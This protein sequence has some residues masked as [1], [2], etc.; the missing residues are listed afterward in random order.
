MKTSILALSLML[1]GA[2]L[3]DVESSNVF[4]L[5]PVTSTQKETLLAVPFVAYSAD[6]TSSI[7]VKDLVKTANLTTGDRLL[8][9]NGSTYYSWTLKNSAWTPDNTAY[10]TAAGGKVISTTA[11]TQDQTISRGDAIWLVRTDTSKT[12]Y[13]MGQVGAVASLS[14]TGSD[15]GT[16]NLVGSTVGDAIKIS[17]LTGANVSDTIELNDGTFYVYKTDGWCKRTPASGWGK[18]TETAVTDSDVIPAG[19][20]FM[21]FAF[22]NNSLTL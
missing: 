11:P 19:T 18:P 8:V 9:S 3:A 10:T 21:Y 22:G 13:L 2:A 15:K 4:G 7:A 1:A 14:I 17:S 12:V 5:I 6:G 20:G 16:W